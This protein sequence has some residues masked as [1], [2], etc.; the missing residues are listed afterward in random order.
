MNELNMDKKVRVKTFFYARRNQDDREKELNNFL[1]QENIV[2]DN[3][4]QSAVSTS[5]KEESPQY[6]DGGVVITIV[7]HH[8]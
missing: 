2:V 1:A 8:V 5:V 6:L 4:L 3:I 7:Y